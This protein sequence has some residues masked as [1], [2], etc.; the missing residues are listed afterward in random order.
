ML[1]NI[2][3]WVRKILSSSNSTLHVCK[4]H[5]SMLIFLSTTENVLVSFVIPSLHYVRFWCVRRNFEAEF[6]A[7]EKSTDVTSKFQTENVDV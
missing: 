2:S 1:S 6:S 7:L 4:V 5:V 3:K